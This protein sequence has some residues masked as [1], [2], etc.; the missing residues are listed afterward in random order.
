ML[1]E[2]K[3]RLPAVTWN[4]CQKF[5]ARFSDEAKDMSTGRSGDSS[6]MS[7]LVF[8]VYQQYQRTDWGVKCLD[9]IDIMILEGVHGAQTGMIEFER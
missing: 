8:R 6:T 9:L 3:Y 5:L 4:V 7:K 1:D 2:S